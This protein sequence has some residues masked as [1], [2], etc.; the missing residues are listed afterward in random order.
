LRH[1]LA[2]SVAAGAIAG[3]AYAEVKQF[4]VAAQ[5][6]ATGIP[7]FGR[8][9]DVQ[10]L[11]AEAAVRGKRSHAVS[12][13]LTLNQGLGQLLAGTGLTVSSNDGHTV[14]LAAA[15]TTPAL[16]VSG[17]AAP[18]TADPLIEEIIVTAQK[19][20]EKIIDIPMAISA[21][22]NETLDRMGAMDFKD[23][24]RLTPGVS[25]RST[26]P[27]ENKIVIRGVSSVGGNSSTTGYYLDDT[28]LNAASANPDISTFDLNRVEFLR[29]PQ[30]TL[31][32]GGSMG[33]TIRFISNVP[34]MSAFKAR[35]RMGVGSI[36]GG[37][38]IYDFAGLINAPLVQDRVA[39][40]ASLEVRHDG[41]WIDRQR[42][43]INYNAFDPSQ[44]QPDPLATR[45]K[46]VNDL[47]VYTFRAAL[48]VQATDNLK[49]T[50]SYYRQDTRAG[51]R[52]SFDEPPGSFDNQLQTRLINE[53]YRDLSE[54]Y[55][56]L[57]EYERNGY[58]VT[59][60]TSMTTRDNVRNDDVSAS[61]YFLLTA[62]GIGDAISGAGLP[63]LTLFPARNHGTSFGR[64]LM[65][66]LRITTPQDKRLR[67]T[68]GAFLN[69]S[70]GGGGVVMSMPGFNQ[71]WFPVF[72]TDDALIIGV[73]VKAKATEAAL[74]GEVYYDISPDLTFTAGLRY[75]NVSHHIRYVQD[76]LLVGASAYP[77]TGQED[78]LN[79][80][81]VLSYKPNDDSLVYASAARGF[82]QGGSNPP[83][84]TPSAFPAHFTSDSLWTYEFG[85]K[86]NAFDHRLTAAAAIYHTDW[87]DLQ[88]EIDGGGTSFTANVGS[89]KIDGAEVELTALPADGLKLT[90]SA[91]YNDARISE[92][93]AS[94]AVPAGERLLDVPKWTASSSV[95]YRRPLHDD[96][97]FVVGGSYQYSSAVSGSFTPDSPDRRRDGYGTA[98][99]R[100]GVEGAD[101]SVTASATNLLDEQVVL[102]YPDAPLFNI[103]G[104]RLVVPLRPRTVSIS[105][106]RNF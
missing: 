56:L 37:D 35:V 100:I 38:A 4:E 32:G 88:Q 30:G 33:G 94:T 48:A 19:R 23:F 62:F 65:E 34:E 52:F 54:V 60:A 46:N 55:T 29:G 71:Q 97:H 69:R 1:A 31:Y 15:S 77:T 104:R 16:L 67:A 47:N 8:Q 75:Y 28:S 42:P 66:E 102:A 101:W 14:T 59:S 24:A 27:D 13:A 6:A 5:P 72:P 87:S 7:E 85:G 11:A 49:L 89:A 61:A 78:G 63:P 25:F 79:P 12:G 98:D 93:G 18:A 64:G 73:D 50:G 68:V 9:A 99:A 106:N 26:G 41:G 40:R 83:P 84:A 2:A 45:E 51:G 103:P 92:A 10:I 74:F 105:F 36:E 22:S 57:A 80:K 58:T 20:D 96:L 90:A 44:Y 39:L 76:G 43:V 86:I 91:G 17:A 53:P 95:E 70:T 3:P 81:F 21:L 82:R